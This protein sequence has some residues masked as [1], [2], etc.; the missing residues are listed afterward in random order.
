MSR[1]PMSS[2]MPV[3]DV[4]SRLRLTTSLFR[5]LLIAQFSPLN[6]LAS[7]SLK[8]RGW[9]WNADPRL[10]QVVIEV[11]SAW[12]PELTGTRPGLIIKRQDWQR[13]RLGLNDEAYRTLDGAVHFANDWM[14][15]HTI[16]CLAGKDGECE[17]LATEVYEFLNQFAPA[18]RSDFGFKSYAVAS[19]G[20]LAKLKEANQQFGVPIDVGYVLEEAW[21]LKQEAALLRRM[22]MHGLEF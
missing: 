19:I 8:S 3:C 17:E 5:Q 21:Q 10:T 11:F 14:G 22:D 2:V 4:K 7:E 18:I 6:E 15:S 1:L 9:I 12:E 13:K 16:F 20:K